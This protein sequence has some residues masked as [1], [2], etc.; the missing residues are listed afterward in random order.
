MIPLANIHKSNSGLLCPVR[1]SA[2]CAPSTPPI[3]RHQPRR[4]PEHPQVVLQSW[5]QLLVVRGV[6]FQYAVATADAPLHFLQPHLAPEL[7]LLCRLAPRYD[8]RVLLE[9][10]H[11]LLARRDALPI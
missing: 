7:S 10:A 9:E 3:G 11:Q 1:L 5:L 2:R 8:R 6:A 4:T